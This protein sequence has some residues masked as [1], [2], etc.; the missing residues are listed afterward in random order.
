MIW[1]IESP[2]MLYEDGSSEFSA[3]LWASSE[4]GKYIVTRKGYL[5]PVLSCGNFVLVNDALQQFFSRYAGEAVSF[6]PAV[7]E[8]RVKQTITTGY[9]RLFSFDTFT[10][11]PDQSIFDTKGIVLWLANDEYIFISDELKLLL[12]NHPVEGIHI[13]PGFGQ[14]VN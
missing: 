10:L 5:S 4:K 14:F 3:G 13:S 1:H 2:V 6:E 9:W 12:E 8:D 11:F 7:I